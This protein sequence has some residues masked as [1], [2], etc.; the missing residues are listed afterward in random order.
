MTDSEK[1]E[2]PDEVVFVSGIEPVKSPSSAAMAI[3]EAQKAA[4]GKP[5]KVRVQGNYRV[6]ENGTH[7]YGGDT[8]EIPHDAEHDRWLKQGWVQPVQARGKAK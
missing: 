8:L 6:T 7:Y 5:V 1:R 4:A 2:K 3:A